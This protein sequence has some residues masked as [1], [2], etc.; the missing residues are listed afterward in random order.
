MTEEEIRNELEEVVKWHTVSGDR[1]L[2]LY[3]IYKL[4]TGDTNK[5]CGVCPAVIIGVA[6]RLKKYYKDNYGEKK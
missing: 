2:R 1:T 5:Y 6:T 4:V 3:A